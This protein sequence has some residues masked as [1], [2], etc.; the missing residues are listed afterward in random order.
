MQYICWKTFFSILKSSKFLYLNKYFQASS[1]LTFCAKITKKKHFMIMI[2]ILKFL[3]CK[4]MCSSLSVMLC[5]SSIFNYYGFNCYH[6]N[7]AGF[8]EHCSCHLSI[9]IMHKV[10]FDFHAIPYNINP[11]FCSWSKN[12]PPY[13]Y[14]F[15]NKG[16]GCF[17]IPISSTYRDLNPAEPYS[18]LIQNPVWGSFPAEHFFNPFS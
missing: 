8:Q 2:I 12:N 17:L 5:V 11:M 13:L 4:H 18:N 3:F 1:V 15:E 6:I 14:F 9:I 10:Q 7:T 16:G